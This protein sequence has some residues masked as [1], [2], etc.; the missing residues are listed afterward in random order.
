MQQ[1]KQIQVQAATVGIEANYTEMAGYDFIWPPEGI[2]MN[3][4]DEA[5]TLNL[6]FEFEFE[7]ECSFEWLWIYKWCNFSHI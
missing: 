7:F 2:M 4:M 5:V 1:Q 6:E 3:V